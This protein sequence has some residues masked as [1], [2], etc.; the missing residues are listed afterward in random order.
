M[1][2]ALVFL[3]IVAAATPSVALEG[4][5]EA[6]GNGRRSPSEAGTAAA[7]GVDLPLDRA[8]AGFA[9]LR[10]MIPESAVHVT[11]SPSSR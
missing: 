3:S 5:E 1:K 11:A 10:V 2:N 7:A 9:A 6:R 8:V 4:C